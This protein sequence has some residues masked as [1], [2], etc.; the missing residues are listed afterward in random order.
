MY[1]TVET[2]SNVG[3]VPTAGLVRTVESVLMLSQYYL[4]CAKACLRVTPLL[5]L[6]DPGF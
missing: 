5:A 6:G 3:L 1:V 2:V 4:V